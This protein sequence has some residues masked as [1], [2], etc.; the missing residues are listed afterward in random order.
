MASPDSCAV[1]AHVHLDHVAEA[2]R[3]ASERLR[4]PAE[5]ITL[6][7]RLREATLPD[8]DTLQ[9][10]GQHTLRWGAFLLTYAPL[11]A[12]FAGIPTKATS[13]PL[14]LHVDKI[15]D[16][17]MRD[18]D[19]RLFTDRWSLHT[20]APPTSADSDEFGEW[21]QYQ[22]THGT[23]LYLGDMK[24]L[25]DRLSHGADPL[26]ATNES[27]AMWSTRRGPSLRML[28]VEGFLNAA[29]DLM[30]HTVHAFGGTA[31]DVPSWPEPRRFPGPAPMSRSEVAGAVE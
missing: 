13:R 26:T 2:A 12:F 23:R 5:M 8:G 7:G 14:P 20:L 3:I 6:H 15:R 28:G 31:A 16:A 17:V 18:H 10:P 25:R 11:E 4:I 9:G 24:S 29:C 1:L 30:T 21:R 22:G 19:I 27:G